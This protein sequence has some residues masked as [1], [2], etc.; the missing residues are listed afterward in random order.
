MKTYDV[1]IDEWDYSFKGIRQ[2]FR[3][4]RTCIHHLEKSGGKIIYH[5]PPP[6]N[7]LMMSKSGVSYAM[8]KYVLGMY[9]VGQS[10]ELKNLGISCCGI[11]NKFDDTQMCIKALH[12]ILSYSQEQC[13]GKFFINVESSSL[14]LNDFVMRSIGIQVEVLIFVI[15]LFLIMMYTLRC[16]HHFQKVVLFKKHMLEQNLF[17]VILLKSTYCLLI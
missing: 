5:C 1:D 8:L 15:Q 17:Q 10:L 4:I 14:V 3:L 9:V 6:L 16:T 2:A 12:K 11:W 13:N 7:S